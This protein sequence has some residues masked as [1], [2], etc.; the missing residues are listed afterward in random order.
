[1]WNIQA[2]TH[3]EQSRRRRIRERQKC[4]RTGD[5]VLLLPGEENI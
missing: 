2:V 1:M 5:S 3:S 4:F